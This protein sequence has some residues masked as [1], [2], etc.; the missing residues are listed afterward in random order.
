MA[1]CRIEINLF[2]MLKLLQ[3]PLTLGL[4]GLLL[5]ASCQPSGTE[6]TETD[7]SDET[8]LSQ[9]DSSDPSPEF[10]PDLD[11]S[12]DTPDTPAEEGDSAA[13]PA[14]QGADAPPQQRS[15]QS[16]PSQSPGQS[17]SAAANGNEYPEEFITG[18]MDGCAQGG[19][20]VEF[21]RCSLDGIQAEFT[22]EEF[23]AIDELARNQQPAPPEVEQ[24]LNRI[25]QSCLPSQ[26]PG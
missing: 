8:T 26:P 14:P 5:L 24:S 25:A 18:F 6:Q 13:A 19:V 7:G 2:T 21:C 17:P 20:P 22:V 1:A 9:D 4:G 15:A 11:L 10:D 3:L 12:L 23:M 16:A